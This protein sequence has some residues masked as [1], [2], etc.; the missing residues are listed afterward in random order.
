MTPEE[1]QQIKDMI[2]A[3]I[4]KPTEGWSWSKFFSGFF[5]GRNYAK[6]IVLGVC[7]LV[8]LVVV[9]SVSTLIK[10]KMS[11]PTTAQTV[12]TNQGIIATQNEDKSG[13]TYSLF[14]LFNWK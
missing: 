11:K 4:A 13:N 7:M 10:S 6:A 12:G 2:A 14:N 9:T 3:D 8:I 5:N 1:I